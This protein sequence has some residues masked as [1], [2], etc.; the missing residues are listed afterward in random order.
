MCF[1]YRILEPFDLNINQS[2]FS[3]ALENA[4]SKAQVEFSS[5]YVLQSTQP[6]TVDI[7]KHGPDSDL[8]SSDDEFFDADIWEQEDAH[9]DPD[10]ATRAADH[11]NT[12][13]TSDSNDHPLAG[14]HSQRLAKSDWTA[15]SFIDKCDRID[16][17]SRHTECSL[18]Q[19]TWCIFQEDCG[20]PKPDTDPLVPELRLTTP[21][22]ADCW[23]DD[24]T[25]YEALP[26]EKEVA[27]VRKGILNV[28]S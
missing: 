8:D 10:I 7:L 2:M 28:I 22:G 27:E 14:L 19:C 5:V 23:L 15:H 18:T 3:P 20:W 12:D 9:N 4:T 11:I 24:P 17:W 25:D 13:N 26:W 6:E 16:I 1:T 21:E